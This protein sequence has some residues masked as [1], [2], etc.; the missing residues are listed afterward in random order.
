M[1][2][3]H[4]VGR[5]VLWGMASR[6]LRGETI[7]EIIGAHALRLPLRRPV[8]CVVNHDPARQIGTTADGTLHLAA[9]ERGIKFRL[10]GHLPPDFRG[11]SF[12]FRPLRWHAEG[13]Q[14]TLLDGVLL[15]VSLLSGRSP[16]Y[17][18]LTA[19][20]IHVDERQD[21]GTS[22]VRCRRA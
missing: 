20:E 15:H 11:V 10:R 19:K 9:D 2:L 13:L 18:Q 21:R 1:R 4:V 17:P 6:V 12:R 5:V 22:H 3:T 14:R 16:A 7:K 8:T